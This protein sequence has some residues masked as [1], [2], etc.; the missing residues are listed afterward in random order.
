[1]KEISSGFIRKDAKAFKPA[2]DTG[3]WRGATTKNGQ[4]ATIKPG[5]S[6]E[7]MIDNQPHK[8]DIWA[9]DT[10]WG[11]QSLFYKLYNTKT[12][13]KAKGDHDRSTEF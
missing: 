2:P 9:F 7:L 10:R 8:L 3:R 13:E 12:A 5:W 6:C 1:M 4:F 11:Q